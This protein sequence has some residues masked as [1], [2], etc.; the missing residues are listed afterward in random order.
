MRSTERQKVK[1]VNLV[2]DL[3]RIHSELVSFFT[4]HQIANVE[5]FDGFAR[6][7][8]L[9]IALNN[10][11]LVI[12]KGDEAFFIGKEQEVSDRELWYVLLNGSLYIDKGFA[13]HLDAIMVGL[14]KRQQEIKAESQ[15]LETLQHTL[16]KGADCVGER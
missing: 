1:K 8:G 6:G 5:R 2:S 3:S 16:I 11:Q 15:A 13:N 7:S 9:R 4:Q 10:T 12:E 14:N